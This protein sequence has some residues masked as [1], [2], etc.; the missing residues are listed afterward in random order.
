MGVFLRIPICAFKTFFL[1][2]YNNL[3]RDDTKQNHN[4]TVLQVDEE[5]Y[6]VRPNECGWEAEKNNFYSSSDTDSGSLSPFF[7]NYK[8]KFVL[9]L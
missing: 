5:G 1:T 9:T 2:I 6:S 7:V 4:S 3:L 8:L